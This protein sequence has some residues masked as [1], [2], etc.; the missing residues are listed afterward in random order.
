MKYFTIKELTNTSYKSIDNTPTNVQTFNLVALIERVLDPAREALGIPITVSS[1]FRNKTI[2]KLVGGAVNSQHTAG[3]AADLVCSDNAKLFRYIR[4][5]LIFDQLIWEFG[6]DNQP[7][8]VHVSYSRQGVNR[9]EV[10]IARHVAG[11][12]R[13]FHA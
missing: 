11:K 4:E 9:K 8:W 12:I 5:N 10:L 7:S 6:D 3:E 1:G 13:Y 2:N